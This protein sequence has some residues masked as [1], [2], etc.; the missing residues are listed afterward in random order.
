[1][2]LLRAISVT[3]PVGLLALA[4]CS[5]VGSWCTIEVQPADAEF[6]VAAVT[7]ADDQSYCVSRISGGQ[8]SSSS[9]TY[10]WTGLRLI[11]AP[12]G[13]PLQSYFGHLRLDGKL[14]LTQ[15]SGKTK[16]T[17][18]LEKQKDERTPSPR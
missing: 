13:R 3:M 11:L 6:P 10:R 2:R 7:F 15:G 14:V 5:L 16:I 9:G 17:A 4:G 18:V 8:T 12:E 1:M